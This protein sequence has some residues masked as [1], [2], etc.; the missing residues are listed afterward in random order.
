MRSTDV[1][2][3]PVTEDSTLAMLLEMESFTP[4]WDQESTI[5]AAKEGLRQGMAVQVAVALYGE[6]VVKLAQKA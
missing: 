1:P 2:N 4:G 3:R 5:A 6:E